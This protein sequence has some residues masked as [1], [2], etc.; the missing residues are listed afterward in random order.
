MADEPEIPSVL[1]RLRVSDAERE[2]V[3]GQLQVAV[4]EGRISLAELD[5]RL[6]VVYSA[7]TRAEVDAVIADLP[8]TTAPE[9]LKVERVKAVSRIRGSWQVP[10]VLFTDCY[11][12]VLRLDF[13]RASIG[14]SEVRI[15]L[16]AHKSLVRLQLPQGSTVSV[17]ELAVHKALVR[18]RVDGRRDSSGGTHFTLTGRLSKALLFLR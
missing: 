9:T 2:Q 8:A 7:G 1:R 15:E 14:H 18:N 11:D 10:A 5:R 17:H 4:G 13:R 12:A 3:A 6:A 16:S